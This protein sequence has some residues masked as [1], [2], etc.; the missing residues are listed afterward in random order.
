MGKAKTHYFGGTQ[1]RSQAVAGAICW[2]YV[3]L[4]GEQQQG[5]SDRP[6]PKVTLAQNVWSTKIQIYATLQ[7]YSA[8]HPEP[9]A[10]TCLRTLL[11]AEEK[12]HLRP[13]IVSSGWLKRL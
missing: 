7:G 2:L 4:F 9:C 11:V 1:G 3:G 10:T 8:T 12:N 5:R 13:S 6:L